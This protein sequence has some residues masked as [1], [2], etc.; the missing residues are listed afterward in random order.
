[1][2]SNGVRQQIFQKLIYRRDCQGRSLCMDISNLGLCKYDRLLPTRV[3]PDVANFEKT[4]VP[5]LVTFW[6]MKSTDRLVHDCPLFMNKEI[7]GIGIESFAI[8]LLH[9]WAL[10]PLGVFIAF[11][12][13]FCLSSRIFHPMSIYLNAEECERIAVLHI[14][15]LLMKYY[16]EK[17]QDEDWKRRGSEASGCLTNMFGE[18]LL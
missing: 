2:A 9:S 14:K 17:R 16:R 5:F 3:V 6:R 1:M 13:W 18:T 8:D 12:F 15:T 4:I 11:V 10:G 7:T